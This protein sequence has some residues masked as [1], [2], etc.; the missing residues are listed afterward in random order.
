M[1]SFSVIGFIDTIKYLPNQGGCFVFVSE[2]KKGYKKSNGEVVDDKYL[3]WKVIF[4][5]GLVKYIN[6][7]FNNGMLVEIKGEVL[8]YAIDKETIVQG[9]SV[10]GQ[11][12]N[13]FSFP[14]SG[15]RQE[16]RMLKD[17]LDYDGDKP[18]LDEY[19]RP[20]F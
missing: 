17:S 20:D 19:N 9:Y 1:A 12:I 5:H 10:I 14:R 15:V 8:P 2:F 18:D 13:L 16:Q 3:S 11:T 6:N 7:H 4:K